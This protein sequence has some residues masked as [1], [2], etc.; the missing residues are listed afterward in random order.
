M[1]IF[2]VDPDGEPYCETQMVPV[3]GSDGEDQP[4]K[5]GNRDYIC[6]CGG[7]CDGCCVVFGTP[8]AAGDL[9]FWEVTYIQ[10][11]CTS[12]DWEITAVCT[13]PTPTGEGF[14][15]LLV[16]TGGASPAETTSFENTGPYNQGAIVEIS[17]T[18]SPPNCPFCDDGTATWSLGFGGTPPFLQQSFN[19]MP[20]SD[21][22]PNPN[23]TGE[24]CRYECEGCLYICFCGYQIEVFPDEGQVVT[25]G[26]PS[27]TS[28]V[29]CPSGGVASVTYEVLALGN[30]SYQITVIATCSKEGEDSDTVT[31]AIEL[32]NTATPECIEYSVTLHGST[33]PI[34][35]GNRRRI[36]NCSLVQAPIR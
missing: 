26:I 36:C 30:D 9:H 35:F 16:G 34:F 23:N 33:Y 17:G 18:S 7:A 21:W 19:A 29:D 10:Y 32:S 27:G 24:L 20:C 22:D 6:D 5:V 28:C 25:N 14:I 8:N 13:P 3:D 15:G 1:T 31:I 11:D 4:V 2:D 12:G